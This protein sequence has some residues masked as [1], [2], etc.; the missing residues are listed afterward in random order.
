MWDTFVLCSN[1]ETA[2]QMQ[3]MCKLAETVYSN[4]VTKLTLTDVYVHF[5]TVLN[6]GDIFSVSEA[7]E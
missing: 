6:N 7:R 1:A 2:V 3:N 4:N 5:K